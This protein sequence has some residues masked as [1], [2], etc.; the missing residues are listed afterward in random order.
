MQTRFVIET[1]L[2]AIDKAAPWRLARDLGGE[3]L[4]EIV[5]E[6]THTCYNGDRGRRHEWGWGC[7][8]C[9]ACG[10]RAAGYA[11]LRAEGGDSPP[12]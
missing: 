2:M 1:P 11:E 3:A 10:L 9:P 5:R 6:E 8:A 7:G 12:R 4:V